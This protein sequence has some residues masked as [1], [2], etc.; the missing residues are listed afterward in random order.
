MR[1]VAAPRDRLGRE[2]DVTPSLPL[3]LQVRDLSDPSNLPCRLPPA[4][5]S[6][7]PFRKPP[8]QPAS[9]PVRNRIAVFFYFV[10]PVRLDSGKPYA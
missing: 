9:S 10:S 2:C 8:L 4:P 1:P 3:S 6:P 5:S 7:R